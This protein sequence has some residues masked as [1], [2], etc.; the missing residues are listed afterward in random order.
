M[1]EMRGDPQMSITT[2]TPP[3]EESYQANLSKEV[4][5]QDPTKPQ[6]VITSIP[7]SQVSTSS[8]SSALL[9]EP[10]QPSTPAQYTLQYG[11]QL[12]E[13]ISLRNRPPTPRPLMFED[14][15][16]SS[17]RTGTPNSLLV[18]QSMAHIPSPPSPAESEL[19]ITSSA[20]SRV[21]HAPIAQSTPGRSQILLEEG[22]EDFQP[23]PSRRV[24]FPGKGQPIRELPPHAAFVT[25]RTSI[26]TRRASGRPMVQPE[27]F[28]Q[29]SMIPEEE[30]IIPA[31]PPRSRTSTEVS[32]CTPE[33][34]PEFQYLREPLPPQQASDT[35]LSRRGIPIVQEIASKEY[36]EPVAC[37]N[38][39]PQ[40]IQSRILTSR[41]LKEMFDNPPPQPPLGGYPPEDPDPYSYD[42]NSSDH[43][44][45]PRRPRPPPG[46]PGPPGPPAG[47]DPYANQAA[48]Q[49]VQPFRPAPVHFDTKLKSDLI[50]E[51]DGDPKA[52]PKW[53]IAVNN[54]A[55]Y[56]Y[57]PSGAMCKGP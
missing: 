44:P 8:I 16:E 15:G 30:V 19:S 28:T 48:V 25:R 53:V 24:S 21:I 40:H 29:V 5:D 33:E 49:P 26:G 54:I 37:H 12:E 14:L 9:G 32:W 46:P 34:P 39:L 27:L 50:P 41:C 4:E 43:K 13:D 52:L 56:C 1:E 42:D 51:W 57:G 20:A 22:P 36:Q 47:L 18:D 2:L 10:A 38:H 23:L 55:E 45:P 31:V 6:I 35:N 7:P 17:V 11:I 3:T